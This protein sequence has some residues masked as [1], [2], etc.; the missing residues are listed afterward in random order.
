M[1]CEV[2]KSQ[3]DTYVDGE[4]LENQSRALDSHVRNC[5][6]CAGDALARVQ[7]K[8][9]LH[10]AGKR[11]VPSGQFRRQMQQRIRRKAGWNIPGFNWRFAI[12]IAAVLV[13]VTI[14]VVDLGQHRTTQ[15][16]SIYTELADL[17]VATLASSSP[18]DV[19]STDRHTVKPWFQGRIPF[20]FDLPELQNSDFYLVGG[21][22]TYLD[23]TPGA[24]LIYQIRKHE[25]SV[26]IFQEEFL[27]HT[28]VEQPAATK[29]LSFKL[30]TWTHG[31]LRYYLVGD[32][33]A[34]DIKTL[35][36]LLKS[37]AGA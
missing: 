3:L 29:E 12:A 30:E 36:G 5:A 13:L 26:F 33:S 31:G 20:T 32:A 22:V 11:F 2:W 14:G 6:S 35:A 27:P 17:H 18:V 1:V 7:R 37:A 28:R 21:R 23:Q 34:L 10:A 15:S 9:Y 19:V 25:I 16:Q 4:L 8:R 24:H